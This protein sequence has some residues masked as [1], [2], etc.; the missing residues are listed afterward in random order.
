MRDHRINN[1]QVSSKDYRLTRHPILSG[2]LLV[3]TGWLVLMFSGDHWHHLA[4]S[5]FMSITMLFASFIAGSTS[6]GGGAVAFP[7]M[8]LVFDIPP[9]VAR[10]FSIMIQ[11]VGMMAASFTIVCMKIPVEWRAVLFAGLGGAI[12]VALGIDVISPMMNPTYTKIF[13]TSVWLS[14]AAALF[15][16][17]R[18]QSLEI[19]ETI[20]GF[21]SQHGLLLFVTGIIGGTVSGIT[22]SG[23]DILIFSLLVLG[24]RINEKVATP[25]SV[26]LMGTNS[27]AGFFYKGLLG[28][29]MEESAWQYWYACIPI[30]VIGAPLGA[31]FIRSRTRLFVAELLYTSILVQYIGALII[32]PITP[33]LLAF[34]GLIVIIGILFFWQM[35]RLR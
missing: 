21:K 3:W 7:V 10:D 18:Y 14:F 13:F 33:M 16:V 8:T 31:W 12:G 20:K 11:S 2:T 5:W 35:T 32:L 15:W 30:V 34:S 25:T 27:L 4:S 29:G 6:E 23:L 26:V 24:F 19:R 22:G 1:F 28:T 9:V 17:N